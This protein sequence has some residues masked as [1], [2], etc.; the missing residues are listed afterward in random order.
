MEH[1]N[2]LGTTLQELKGGSN[3]TGTYLPT[4]SVGTELKAVADPTHFDADPK[5]LFPFPDPRFKKT[6]AMAKHIEIKLTNL[7]YISS[8]LLW[9]RIRKNPS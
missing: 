9:I 8:P 6:H 3:G 5:T 2:S 7:A 1:L 4:V